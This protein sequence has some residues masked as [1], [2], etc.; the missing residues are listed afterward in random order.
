M[1]FVA[2]PNLPENSV[3]LAVVDGRISGEAEGELSNLGVKLLKLQ[4]HR[5]LYAAVCS[6][7]DM[8]LHHIG[9]EKIVYAPGTDPTLLA[10]LMTYGFKLLK[11]ESTLHPAYPADIAYNIA[12]VGS[13]YFHNLKYTDPV[14]K[15]Q[16]EKLGVE[17]VHV[18]QGYSKCSVLPIDV[19]SIITSDAGIAKAAEKKG[20][21]VLLVDCERSIRLP[22]LN[23]GFIGGA[24]GMLGGSVCALN[25]GTDTLSCS[26]AIS[27]FVSKK[28]II[29]KGLSDDQVTDIGSILPLMMF[30][31]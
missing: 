22:G 15:K 5:S 29:I 20:L 14:I 26:E 28:N 12:R 17:P 4:P 11:G 27:A 6:H 1:F 18:E 16:L 30:E 19:N 10:A 3:N 25:G 9:G 13:R 24:G 23:Y 2:K 7:P 21:E 8:L 31:R